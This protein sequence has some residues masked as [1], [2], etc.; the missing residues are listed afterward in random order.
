MKKVILIIFISFITTSSFAQKRTPNQNSPIN[1]VEE[2]FR[3]ART[4]D[5]SQIHL[6]CDP[7]GKGD[8]DTKELCNIK[9]QDHTTKVMFRQLFKLAYSLDEE[10]IEKQGAK[11]NFRFG[12][13][14]Q[15]QETMHLVK[16]NGKW[17]LSSF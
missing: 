3:C 10:I 17:Y 1:T 13:K 16:R 5:F 4:G 7:L 8:G 2:I 11:V 12:P 15:Q 6:L 14:A 9:L